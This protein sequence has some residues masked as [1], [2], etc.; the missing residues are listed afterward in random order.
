MS[1]QEKQS[2][3]EQFLDLDNPIKLG[4]VKC[5]PIS[6][7]IARRVHAKWQKPLPQLPDN[8]KKQ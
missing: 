8:Q 6:I 5:E 1:E 3:I 2:S 4:E 7:I